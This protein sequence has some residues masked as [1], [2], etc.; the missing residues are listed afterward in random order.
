MV[1]RFISFV[2][3]FNF[4]LSVTECYS[5]GGREQDK[6]FD[7]LNDYE[8][9]EMQIEEVPYYQIPPNYEVLVNK[10]D[11]L[12]QKLESRFSILTTLKEIVP[13][14]PLMEAYFNE[15]VTNNSVQEHEINY[16]HL[17][18]SFIRT[19]VISL[20]KS[21]A[22][23][24][25]E[26]LASDLDEHLLEYIGGD[27]ESFVGHPRTLFNLTENLSNTVMPQIIRMAAMTHDEAEAYFASLPIPS[28]NIQ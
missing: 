12:Y 9:F 13:Y 25:E 6:L 4:L 10:F 8:T 3:V 7:D 15:I 14:G 18:A 17:C 11:E 22:I 2:L 5:K 21:G 24:Q 23:D 26:D 20:Y 16:Y 1:K 28:L 27:E 19:G